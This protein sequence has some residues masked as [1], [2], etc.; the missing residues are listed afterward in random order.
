MGFENLECSA[1]E[2]LLA[3]TN[4]RIKSYPHTVSRIATQSSRSNISVLDTFWIEATDSK[5]WKR[6]TITP[7][8]S[9]ECNP[10]IPSCKSKATQ[11]LFTVVPLMRFEIQSEIT[12]EENE[13]IS[14]I[15]TRLE[16]S[17]ISMILNRISHRFTHLE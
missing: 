13:W 17:L 16:N 5:S 9:E 14:P 8:M 3:V 1:I 2:L 11:R 7:E 12:E 15:S 6:N 10:S 4:D